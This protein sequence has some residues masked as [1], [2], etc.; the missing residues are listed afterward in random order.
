[1]PRPPTGT[2]SRS[3]AAPRTSTS[4]PADSGLS[5]A[6]PEVVLLRHGETEWSRD[7]RHTGKTD[8]PLTQAGRRQAKALGPELKPWKFALVLTS[9][10]QRAAE[11]CRLAG[12][13]K[14]AKTRQ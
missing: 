13:G 10:L 14:R 12:Y 2:T 3:V 1:M 9:P 5:L 6:K 8:I 11:T 7:G 4:R